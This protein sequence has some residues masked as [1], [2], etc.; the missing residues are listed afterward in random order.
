MTNLFNMNLQNSDKSKQPLLNESNQ[1]Q[2]GILSFL[3]N[4][5]EE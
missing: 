3:T 1:N 2:G 4:N 5:Q